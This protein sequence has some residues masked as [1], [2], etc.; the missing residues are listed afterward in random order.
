VFVVVYRLSP[1]LAETTPPTNM[2]DIRGNYVNKVKDLEWMKTTS[3]TVSWMPMKQNTSQLSA[4]DALETAYTN[5]FKDT[6][7]WKIDNALAGIKSA[8]DMVKSKNEDKSK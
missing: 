7:G 3:A 1:V 5:Q 6:H 4:Y 8:L 2:L